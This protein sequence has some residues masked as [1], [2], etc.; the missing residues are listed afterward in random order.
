MPL[1]PFAPS[2]F[3]IAAVVACLA[4]PRFAASAATTAPDSPAA[5]TTIQRIK[6]WEATPDVVAGRDTDTDPTEPTLDIYPVTSATPSAPDTGVSAAPAMIILPGGG[7]T[8]LSTIKEGKDVANLLASHG[9]ASFVLRYRHAPRYNKL[10]PLQDAQRAL[11]IV[12]NNA[13][14]YHID[15]HRI[16]IM[17]FSAGG[18]LAALAATDTTAPNADAPDAIDRVSARPDFAVL[19]YAVINLDDPAVTH[20]GSR[21]ALV[22]DDD[23]LATAFSAEKRVTKETPPVFIVHAATDR[24]VPVQNSILFFQ[25]CRKAGVP[26]EMHIFPSGPHG[27]GLAP[28]DP[29]L[30][31]WPDLMLHWMTTSH[32][33]TPAK[34]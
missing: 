4:L 6:L 11:R 1:M 9:V 26:A 27:F 28:K 22:G 24:T 33:L 10:I 18:S 23:K 8:H 14:Q 15:P 34:P 7:Y 30:S 3:I 32:W 25:A 16:G 29:V 19:V 31:P 5:Q 20:K 12:R 21:D 17:G 13:A 2:A